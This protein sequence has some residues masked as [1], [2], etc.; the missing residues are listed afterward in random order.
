[1]DK[2]N[3]FIDS[4]S[5]YSLLADL[6]KTLDYLDGKNPKRMRCDLSNRLKFA[7][8]RGET[9]N[10]DCTYFN[11]TFYKKGTCHITFRD[12]ARILIDRLNIHVGKN[13]NWLP[14]NYGKAA[15]RDMSNEERAVVD[16]FDGNEEN[17]NKVFMNQGQYL[18]ETQDLLML[19]A[20]N[21]TLSA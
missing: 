14:P 11:V 20:G 21:T 18:I 6:E 2:A 13:K 12:D 8:K 10:I 9:K 3:D 15:Y 4:R 1:M 7:E 5:C 19:S 16:S 17:Y